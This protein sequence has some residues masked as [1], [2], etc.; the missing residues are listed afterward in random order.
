MK[1]AADEGQVYY[2]PLDPLGRSKTF[3]D[4][5]A[6]EAGVKSPSKSARTSK[7]GATPRKSRTEATAQEPARRG[8]SAPVDNP[9]QSD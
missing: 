4:A 7:T 1:A 9:A 3:L 2:A 6:W 8:R 5:S